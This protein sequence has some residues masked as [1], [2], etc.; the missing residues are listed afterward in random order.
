MELEEMKILWEEMSQDLEQQK[1]LTDK[2]IID[3]TNERFKNKMR[4]IS[5]PETMGAIVCFG[6][7]LFLA[8]NFMKLD[9]WYLI[10]CGAFTLGFLTLLPFFSLRSIYKMRHINLADENVKQT[11]LNFSKA[12][13]QFLLIQKLGV[14]LSF[15][16]VITSLPVASK[17]LN[18]TDIFTKPEVLSWFIPAGFIFLFFFGRWGYN[19]YVNITNS[20]ENLLKELEA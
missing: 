1:N 13:S 19:C 6:M 5:G 7:A 10:L 3:M 17:I 14:I 18:G 20:A 11:L 2:I 15:V 4:S 12:K 8:I 9:T 16:L